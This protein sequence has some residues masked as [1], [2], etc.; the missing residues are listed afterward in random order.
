MET[1]TQLQQ[2]SRL[3][4]ETKVPV[5][6]SIYTSATAFFARKYRYSF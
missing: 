3:F 2:P 1:R 4:N 5:E 6:E